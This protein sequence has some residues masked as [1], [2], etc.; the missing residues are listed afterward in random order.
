MDFQTHYKRKPAPP[1]SNSGEK[2]VETAGYITAQQR[3][4]SILNAGQRLNEFRK[5]QFDF[6]T[7]EEFDE[8]FED[9]TRSKNFDLA[10]GTFLG[11]VLEHK[12]RIADEE[13][14]RNKYLKSSQTAQEP[15]NEALKDPERV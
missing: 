14:I 11:S 9:P 7:D 6:G 12:K 2:L 4:E 15:Q 5:E 1:E 8:D 13:A 3:I 10:D